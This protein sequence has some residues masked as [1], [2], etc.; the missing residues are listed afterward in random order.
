SE[1]RLYRVIAERLPQTTVVS[2]GHRS[3][4]HDFH[5]RKVELIREGDRF[6]LRPTTPAAA[7]DAPTGGAE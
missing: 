1:A 7:A 2:I 5:D 3:T 4:L 6:T